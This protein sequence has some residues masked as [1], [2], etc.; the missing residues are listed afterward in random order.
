MPPVDPSTDHIVIPPVENPLTRE[1][2]TLL[3]ELFDPLSMSDTCNG[4][5]VYCAVR[6]YVSE[7]LSY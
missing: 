3:C 2:Y 1:E 7:I 4:V 5:D 6:Q